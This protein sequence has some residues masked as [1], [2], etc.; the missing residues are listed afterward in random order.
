[1]KTH[2]NQTVDSTNRTNTACGSYFAWRN[3]L[4]QNCFRSGFRCF[5]KSI[6]F[7]TQRNPYTASIRLVQMLSVKFVICDIW[8]CNGNLCRQK[9]SE[10]LM[11]RLFVC[12]GECEHWSHVH[13]IGHWLTECERRTWNGFIKF[14]CNEFETK[15]ALLTERFESETRNS[16]LSAA[17]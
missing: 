15:D 13:V 8:K 9:C 6:A 11:D 5:P 14:I 17:K 7:Q 12:S 1:M 2:K 10:K 4:L 3:S 16:L